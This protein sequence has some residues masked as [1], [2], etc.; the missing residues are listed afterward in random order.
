MLASR[1]AWPLINRALSAAICLLAFSS[2]RALAAQS[3]LRPAS[4]HAE[5]IA[6][7]WW[8]MLVGA[9]IIFAAVMLILALGQWR[10][11]R[12]RAGSLGAS[13]SRNLVV[14]AGVII[15]LIT[16]IALVG[17]SLALGNSITSTP[18]ENAIRIR[19]TGWMW[20]WEIE[21]LDDE[22]NVVAA[23]AN[24]IHVPV[25]QPVHIQLEAADVI[26]SF[27]VPEL[28]GK[29]DMVPGI[30]N[31]SWFTATKAG[32]FRGQCAE[33]C[34]RQHALMAFLVIAEPPE[35]YAQWLAHQKVSA[36]VPETPQQRLGQKVFMEAGC[37]H[38]HR[39]RGTAA[40]G[41]SAPDL[42]H[43]AT[44]RTLAAVT[45]PNNRGHLTG[46]I[47][48]PQSI[49]PGVFMPG[50]S[51]PSDDFINLTAYLESLR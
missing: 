33:F 2:A 35:D 47:A 17:G 18:P 7:L 20:W 30:V 10:A 31:D 25:G 24:E 43:F 14:I 9:V 48:D 32:V 50:F 8:V 16:I 29:T 26:H 12:G 4:A 22:G 36:A 21:Y 42:T 41:D 28:Q 44:R 11:R 40:D 37:Q 3:A 5:G 46:W 19:V 38:C 27:W 49:K 51:L 39:I 13:A 15:P 23:T 1:L 45:I 6:I 34:G